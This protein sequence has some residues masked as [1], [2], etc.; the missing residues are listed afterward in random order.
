MKK[1]L[2]LFVILL[3]SVMVFGIQAKAAPSEADGKFTGVVKKV[4]FYT[5]NS[6][7]YTVVRF[8]DGRVVP[9]EGI[10]GAVPIREGSCQT[11]WYSG[12]WIVTVEDCK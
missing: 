12:N 5:S 4:E 7:Q 9:F 3:L 8:K 1:T 2:V 10:R 11:I 6:G